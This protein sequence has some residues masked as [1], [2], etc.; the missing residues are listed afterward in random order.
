MMFFILFIITIATTII[1]AKVN[2]PKIELLT[3]VWSVYSISQYMIILNQGVN[4]N[5]LYYSRTSKVLK[6]CA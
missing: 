3:P 4:N 1:S 2:R 5:L 6:Q